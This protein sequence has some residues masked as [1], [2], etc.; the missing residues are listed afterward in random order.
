MEVDGVTD[1]RMIR[2]FVKNMNVRDSSALR[3][4]INDNEPGI[5]YNITIEKPES[6]GGG[7]MSVFLQLD[8][9]IFLN[10]AE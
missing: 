6:L 9:Y 7:S 10:V 5:D 3:K 2:D 1:R 4:Y 8:Q